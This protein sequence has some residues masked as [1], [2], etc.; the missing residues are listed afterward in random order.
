MFNFSLCFSLSLLLLMLF[1][2]LV[3]SIRF[4]RFRLSRCRC[5]FVA[6]HKETFVEMTTNFEYQLDVQCFHPFENV[7]YKNNSD[8]ITFIFIYSFI[9][10]LAHKTSVPVE[11]NR[12]NALNRVKNIC[13]FF[14]FLSC[15]SHMWLPQ[16]ICTK[17]HIVCKVSWVYCLCVFV[18]F[19]VY[20]I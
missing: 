8:V 4:Y 7:E 1:F 19:I 17:F 18:S 14:S 2:C 12:T 13:I 3:S 20:I 16:K 9:Y 6:L 15:Y 10:F 11:L 5:F